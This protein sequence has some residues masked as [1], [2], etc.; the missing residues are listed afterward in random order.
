[1]SRVEF[2][3]NM[4]RH[5]DGTAV[6]IGTLLRCV[7]KRHPLKK[8]RMT[9]LGLMRVNKDPDVRPEFHL[10]F[11]IEG[12]GAPRR[13]DPAELPALEVVEKPS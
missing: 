10:S 13:F 11:R 8:T 9:Y 5:A 2:E 7:E 6:E 4:L 12:D 1:M 3:N